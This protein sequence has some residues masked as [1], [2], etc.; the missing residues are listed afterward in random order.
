MVPRQPPAQL[1][2]NTNPSKLNEYEYCFFDQSIPLDILEKP[3]AEVDKIPIS[4]WDPIFQ[5]YPGVQCEDD[6]VDRRIPNAV[7][8]KKDHIPQYSDVTHHEPPATL[9]VAQFI[10]SVITKSLDDTHE[11]YNAAHVAITGRERQNLHRDMHKIGPGW[12]ALT[13]FYAE[14]YDLNAN[15]GIDTIMLPA[16]R[17]GLPRSWEPLPVELIRGSFFVMYSDLIHAGE[18]VPRTRPSNSWRKAGFLGVANFPVTYQFTPGLHLPFW[19]QPDQQDTTLNTK[20]RCSMERCRKQPTTTCFACN[21]SPLC[22][23]HSALL[24]PGCDQLQPR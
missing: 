15:D 9:A 20:P 11:L 18:A 12:R 17:G 3:E 2:T 23:D 5:Q 7:L 19:A 6:T 16:S 22:K 13:V 10:L 8:A 21:L 4:E 1:V 14:N 24:C